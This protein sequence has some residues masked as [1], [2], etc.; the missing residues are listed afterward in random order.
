M[1]ITSRPLTRAALVCSGLGHAVPEVARPSCLGPVDALEERSE[2]LPR[3]L[4]WKSQSAEPQV[5]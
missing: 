4:T 5:T 2:V 3:R 1:A